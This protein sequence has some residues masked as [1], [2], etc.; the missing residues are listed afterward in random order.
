MKLAGR[1]FLRVAHIFLGFEA[2]WLGFGVHNWTAASLL[3]VLT[4]LLA[5]GAAFTEGKS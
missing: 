3:L 4:P 2:G 1:W 5:L